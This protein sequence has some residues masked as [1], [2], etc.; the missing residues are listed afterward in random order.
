MPSRT[1]SR[2]WFLQ[3]GLALAGLS[4]L[5]GCQSLPLRASPRVPRIAVFHPGV[6]DDP[7]I[8]A[9]RD[10]FRR[11]LQE[12]GYT[13]GRNIAVDWRFA[14]GHAD[15]NGP[16]VA[17]LIRREPDV[18]LTVG[19]TAGLVHQATTTIPIVLVMPGDPASVGLVKSIAHPGGNA[20]G[21]S[22]IAPELA[23]KRLDLL[24]EA[25]PSLTSVATL[26]NPG[27]QTMLP[28]MGATSIAADRLGL[29][30]Q[31]VEVR[32]ESE[33]PGAFQTVTERRIDGLVVVLSP[34]FNASRQTM[35]QLAAMSRLPTISADREFAA[36]GGLMAYGPRL[37]EMWHRAASYVDKLL[38]G[39]KPGDLPVEQPTTFECFINLKTAQTLGLTIPQEVLAQATEVIQ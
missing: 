2:R 30:F 5:A 32:D 23:A 26:W 25:V 7:V 39:A 38:K 28:E 8:D 16:L 27:D 19:Q 15:R 29:R 12:L 31:A 3:S 13:E 14:E 22:G 34:L 11:G 20:T 9:N 35:V 36:A 24:K 37:V 21:L 17:D 33:I 18:I 6:A 4:V 10:A 1:P